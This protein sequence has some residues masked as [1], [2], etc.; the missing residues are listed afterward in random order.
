MPALDEFFCRERA[1]AVFYVRKWRWR[2]GADQQSALLRITEPRPARQVYPA[3]N[4]ARERINPLETGTAGSMTSQPQPEPGSLTLAEGFARSG[5]TLADVWV[6]YLAL[7]GTQS[8]IKIAPV[9][10]GEVAADREQ[11]NTLAAAINE[12]FVDIAGN[13]SVAYL[14]Q[15]GQL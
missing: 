4:I 2:N 14:D 13:H 7:G 12:H 9:L 5:L 6:M 15:P 3:G 11:H 10:H 8:L 1:S